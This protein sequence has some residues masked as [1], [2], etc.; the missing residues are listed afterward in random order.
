MLI[1][2]SEEEAK[3]R[4]ARC[5]IAL[6]RIAL[7]SGWRFDREA[8]AWRNPQGEIVRGKDMELRVAVKETFTRGDEGG[9]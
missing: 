3:R 8:D 1:E 5:L 9:A 2:C 6:Y 4:A 7:E